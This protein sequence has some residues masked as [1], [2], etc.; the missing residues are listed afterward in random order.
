MID[1]GG[2]ERRSPGLARPFRQ[3]RQQSHGIRP[4]GDGHEQGRFVRQS[5]KQGGGLVTADGLWIAGNL[6]DG[7]QAQPERRRSRSTP[8]RSELGAEG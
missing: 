1:G 5:G 8:C 7:A 4:A 3:E 6:G 2:V